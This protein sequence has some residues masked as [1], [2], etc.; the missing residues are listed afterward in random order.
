LFAFW[1]RQPPGRIGLLNMVLPGKIA[2]HLAF[3]PEIGYS[4]GKAAVVALFDVAAFLT[5]PH[6][7][8]GL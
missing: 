8:H 2:E 5:Y 1:A 6:A 7:T 3:P 4:C